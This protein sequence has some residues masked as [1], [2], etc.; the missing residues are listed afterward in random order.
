[1]ASLDWR[2][3]TFAVSAVVGYEFAL[4]A[5]LLLPSGSEFAEEFRRSCFGYDPASGLVS[6]IVVSTTLIV[7]LIVLV[8][9]SIVWARELRAALRARHQAVAGC[10]ALGL[11]V[12]FG[13]VAL[14]AAGS[15][16]YE[17]DQQPFPS[18]ALRTK[19][20][21]PEFELT[22]HNGNTVRLAD[23]RGSVVLVTGFFASCGYACPM[24][25]SDI[26]NSV[27]ALSPEQLGDLR[28]AGIT[29]DPK[30]DTPEVLASIA[31]ARGFSSPPFHLLTDEPAVVEKTLDDLAFPRSRDADTGVIIHPNLY[32]LLD[33]DGRVAYRFAAGERQQSWLSDALRLLLDER[34]RESFE[35]APTKRG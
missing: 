1:L 24:L 13:S 21:A 17:L 30:N 8:V 34:N 5:L 6:V 16:S 12:A 33:R 18:E 22:D 20:R 7:P 3:P 10:V 14:L 28:I 27:A 11:T 15:A 23:L 26:Q 29:L 2:F 25:L 31:T 4:L 19:F 32:I 35:S 9:A